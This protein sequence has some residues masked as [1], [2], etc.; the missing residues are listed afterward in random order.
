MKTTDA[1]AA[2]YTSGEL[3]DRLRTALIDDGVDPVHPTVDALAPYDQFHGR[4][5]EATEE[6]A[7][8]LEVGAGDQLLDVGSGL[9]GP[10]RY[11][12]QHFGCHVTG[13]DLTEEF[14]V[15]ARYLT[16]LVKLHDRVTIHHGSALA[17]PFEAGSFDGVY[18]MNVSMNIADKA[19]LYREIHRV[20]RPDGWLA[21]SEIA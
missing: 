14:C 18:T 8:R 20:L 10:A 1:I 6:M 7:G 12:A 15:L 4:G 9:G 11:L 19:E 13:I 2:H 5:L 3:W 16:R 21:L 17:M